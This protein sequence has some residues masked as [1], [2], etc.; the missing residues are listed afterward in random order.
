MVLLATQKPQ[1]NSFM[2]VE[3][4]YGDPFDP[5]F[6]RFTDNQEE[7]PVLGNTGGPWFSRPEMK[8]ELA[9]NVGT[10]SQRKTHV[11]LEL[12]GN[13]F[14]TNASSGEAH[15]LIEMT[16]IEI[17]EDF[18]GN[19]DITWP[20]KGRCR[21]GWKNP[22]GRTGMVRIEARTCFKDLERSLGIVLGPQCPW[23]LYGRGCDKQRSDDV[24]TGTITTIVGSKV[25]ITG[26]AD[27]SADTTNRYWHLGNVNVEGLPIMV[28]D[29]EIGDP[30][31]FYFVRPPPARWLGVSCTVVPGCDKHPLTCDVRHDNSDRFAGIGWNTPSYNPTLDVGGG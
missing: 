19:I 9:E 6:E 31:N 24:E 27:H 16:I 17:V 3:F 8:I 14:L 13:T 1:K 26:L 18:D 23:Y 10:L 4:K 28:L 20:Y 2:L 22:G 21:E 12:R 29:W 25:T 30:T 5:K 7:V 11:E 15:S